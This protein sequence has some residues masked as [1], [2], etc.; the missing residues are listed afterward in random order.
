MKDNYIFDKAKYH[1]E[2]VEGEGL[3]M[4]QAYVHTG[5][6]FGWLLEHGFCNKE[7]YPASVVQDF[8]SRRITGPELFEQDDG[9]L[10]S[11]LLT[12]EGDAFSRAYFDFESGQYI[13]DYEEL[14]TGEG[15]EIFS[16]KDTWENYEKISARIEERFAQWKAAPQGR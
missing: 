8:K 5:M 10:M 12:E 3:P 4:E 2:S 13:K 6:Y 11:E 1:F 7:F 14:V 9:V 15:A 16:G